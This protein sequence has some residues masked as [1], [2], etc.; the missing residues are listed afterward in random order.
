MPTTADTTRQQKQTSLFGLARWYAGLLLLAIVASFFVNLWA[1]HEHTH[2]V[3]LDQGLVAVQRD[4]E[5][6]A[7]MLRFYRGVLTEIAKQ[8]EVH[9]L[10][11]MG[12]AASA[13]DWALQERRLL[14][15]SVGLALVSPDEH[16]LGVP[17]D[18]RV[19]PACMLD[20]KRRFAS[21][22][23]AEPLVHTDNPRL[24]HFDL[25]QRVTTELGDDRGV[26]FASFR[27]DALQMMLDRSLSPGQQL[28]LR[29]ASG[30]V[31][32][33][34]GTQHAETSYVY[35][36]T[37]VPDTAWTLGLA[38][39][40]ENNL[41]IY[42]T[43]GGTNLATS[44]LVIAVFLALAVGLVRRLSAEMID[45][46]GLLTRVKSGEPITPI[47]GRLRE[48]REL[49]PVI[50][51]IAAD[52]QRT[53]ARLQELSLT[54]ELTQLS[55]RRRF[56]LEIERALDLAGRGADVCLALLDLDH[57]K[58]V[59][60]THGHPA[61]DRLL[62]VL[63]E[64]LRANHRASDFA[65]R[66]GGDEF[67]AL[68]FNMEHGHLAEWTVR[69]KRDFARRLTA[70]PLL[71]D[72]AAYCSFSVG[73]TF[74][75]NGDDMQRLFVRADGALYAAKAAGRDRLQLATA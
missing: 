37:A 62:Q 16:V 41:P 23:L 28:V 59:N 6:I 11:A 30:A 70:E 19:G 44:V 9:D 52:L 65:A 22:P 45:V 42:L 33:S 58:K 14:T 61:G 15:S 29:D 17:V 27:L 31:I 66:L 13:Q 7:S 3:N 55:N 72:A 32:A 12:D 51:D 49:L 25:T 18:L 20:L 74:V 36:Q 60:D 73:A 26:L 40:E 46:H 35:Q 4:A 69:L 24:A 75:V 34:A 5:A 38:Y 1:V 39:P 67:A 43:L 48:T 68:F 54:D 21:E 63:A 71:I 56:N 2:R 50:E 10:L 53:N 47:L 64:A 57:F 8:S